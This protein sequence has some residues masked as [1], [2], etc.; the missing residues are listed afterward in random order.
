MKIQQ[1]LLDPLS[2]KRRLID[3]SSQEETP[4]NPEN[5]LLPGDIERSHHHFKN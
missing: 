4:K 2:I 3:I 5:P 1:A